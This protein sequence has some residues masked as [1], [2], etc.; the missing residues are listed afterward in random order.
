M[1]VAA[2]QLFDFDDTFA[3]ELP[4]LCVAWKAAPF[5]DPALPDATAIQGTWLCAVHAQPAAALTATDTVPPA[6]PAF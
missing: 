5:P 6:L 1:T 3:R 2:R 4:E